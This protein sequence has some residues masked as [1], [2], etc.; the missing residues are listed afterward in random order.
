MRKKQAIRVKLNGKVIG[1][2]YMVIIDIIPTH[3]T[4]VVI[5]FNTKIPQSLFMLYF[6]EK[7]W[8]D[9]TITSFQPFFGLHYKFRSLVTEE[10]FRKY[11]LLP[12]EHK[13]YID[14]PKLKQR[15]KKLHKRY[16]KKE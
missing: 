10:S 15:M 2:M 12:E 4:S 1:F 7:Y 11:E 9:D 3:I 6:A 8:H 14:R 13:L 5:Y 16:I